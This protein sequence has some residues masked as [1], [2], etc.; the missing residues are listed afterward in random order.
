MSNVN[1]L[2]CE[3]I[4]L[5]EEVAIETLPNKWFKSNTKRRKKLPKLRPDLIAKIGSSKGA[6]WAFDKLRELRGGRSNSKEVPVAADDLLD[7]FFGDSKSSPLLV[8]DSKPADYDDSSC[9]SFSIH[10][11]YT[12]LKS[13][14]PSHGSG[15]DS[16]SNNMLLNLGPR[17]LL[18][19][20]RLASLSFRRGIFPSC[21]K[22]AKV[23]IIPKGGDRDP[24]LPSSYRP[25][26]LTSIVSKCLESL[27]GNRCE[28]LLEGKLDPRQSGFTPGR[29][30]EENISLLVDAASG[31]QKLYD[32]YGAIILFD[33][34][35]AFD[36]VDHQIL[37]DRLVAVLP[38]PYVKWL[39]NYLSD[40]NVSLSLG[41]DNG[42]RSCTKGVPQGSVLGPLL[43]RIFVDSL[44][45]LISDA[46]LSV[47]FAD[48]LAVF[49]Q[50]EKIDGIEAKGLSVI[51]QIEGWMVSSKMEVN[52]KKTEYVAF[53]KRI[54]GSDVEWSRAPR[55]Y[56]PSSVE[57]LHMPTG[58]AGALTEKLSPSIG[59][60]LDLA[61]ALLP[62]EI[63]GYP[64][65]RR[66]DFVRL[67]C[68]RKSKEFRLKAAIP[69]KRV[70]S[71]KYLGVI[72]DD[73]L[74]FDEQVDKIVKTIRAGCGLLKMFSA[75]EVKT[76]TLRQLVDGAVLSR[77][78]FGLKAFSPFL[79]DAQ[80][81]R[82]EA[83]LRHLRIRLTGCSFSTKDVV[84]TVESRIPPLQ[85]TISRLLALVHE[86]L[87]RR[88]PECPSWRLFNGGEKKRPWQTR[89][90]ACSSE[91]S[92]SELRSQKVLPHQYP[93]WSKHPPLVVNTSC[94]YDKTDTPEE[95]Y[96][97]AMTTLNELPPCVA[98]VYTDA[99]VF[100]DEER[101]LLCGG[102][103]VLLV[104][105]KVIEKLSKFQPSLTIYNAEQLA[106]LSALELL[107]E[108]LH[109][110]SHGVIHI[111]S[112]CQSA[113]AS[114]HRGPSR[115][116]SSTNREIFERSVLLDRPLIFQHVPSHCGI[117]GNELADTLAKKAALQSVD[118][119]LTP[120]DF[121]MAQCCIKKQANWKAM[122]TVDSSHSYSKATLGSGPQ[123]FL[124][125]LTRGQEVELSRLRTSHHRLVKLP[126][127]TAGFKCCLFCGFQDTSTE[128]LLLECVETR[129]LVKQTMRFLTPDDELSLDMFFRTEWQPFT[130]LLISKLDNHLKE[131]SDNP[132]LLKFPL[133]G[134]FVRKKLITHIE[135]KTS[136]SLLGSDVK[137]YVMELI[138][139]A[140]KATDLN[141]V[142]D[143]LFMVNVLVNPS[144]S[145]S[146]L[147]KFH[148]RLSRL[149]RSNPRGR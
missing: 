75:Y 11:L 140:Y 62:L 116:S 96:T 40:R 71:A 146:K 54:S 115:Q 74:C 129:E 59:A 120:Y 121:R 53:G 89:V 18:L 16:V 39:A 33:I 42:S 28:H 46:D 36:N 9:G 17:M 106:L 29:N 128:H 22:K 23:I 130:L 6:A 123:R 56:F 149:L 26:S 138:D 132:L 90:E 4:S 66:S 108:N 122:G 80:I 34:S 65:T 5:I 109:V 83:C 64:V 85:Q 63:D 135:R 69:L 110:V 114:L 41:L 73:S 7:H 124:P 91:F 55:F 94:G 112:D 43:F 105:G 38:V 1:K 118:P 45:G 100:H 99:S 47:L 52:M 92:L 148:S 119:E 19:L 31:V 93:P 49:L 107:E 25:I 24:L 133:Q 141:V 126:R 76:D 127:V 103:A 142:I 32:G 72:I 27:V 104:A 3:F 37:V 86:D 77:A 57:E 51:S 14:T 70:R 30:V 134:I 101:G 113:L 48:D 139:N 15:L 12:V 84:L 147:S 61:D 136:F 117:A 102:A 2:G 13:L 44:P 97:V 98:E 10:E 35:G 68:A 143:D 125:C 50:H 144:W 67:A 81:K 8:P 82:I 95:K 78:F 145:E 131:L 88:Q 60:V 21:M 111:F 58:S 79:S 137:K 20:L 87:L